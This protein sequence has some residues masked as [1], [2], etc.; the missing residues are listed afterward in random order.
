[1]PD[2]NPEAA[3]AASAAGGINKPN[4][5]GLSPDGKFLFV[6]EYG[7]TNAW[8]FMV[9]PDGNA[10]G[11]RALHGIA[12]AVNR[13]DS[14]GDGM[15]VDQEGRPFITSHCGIQMFDATGAIRRCDRQAK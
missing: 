3:V 6:S 14:G 5:I 1:V 2:A 11:R 8:S 4:G 13:P 10:V 9:N 15:T 12:R 7:G